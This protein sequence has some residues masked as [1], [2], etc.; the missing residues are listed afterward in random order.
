MSNLKFYGLV[1]VVALLVSS[2]VI[3]KYPNGEGLLH[4]THSANIVA[5]K[6]A[7]FKKMSQ[8]SV[9]SQNDKDAFCL[10]WGEYIATSIEKTP[11][12]PPQVVAQRANDA[13]LQQ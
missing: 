10:C 9:I 13:C 1:A 3:I 12:I 5:A 8:D 11:S 7:C 6:E 2:E 4:P